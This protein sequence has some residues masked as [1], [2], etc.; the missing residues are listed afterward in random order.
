MPPFR[1]T[2]QPGVINHIVSED[3]KLSPKSPFIEVRKHLRR[4]TELQSQLADINVAAR[5]AVQELRG[6]EPPA[7]EGSHLGAC[8]SL[9][10][11]RAVRGAGSL[12]RRPRWRSTPRSRAS[13][14]RSRLT[15]RQRA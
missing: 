4:I 3:E 14:R 10:H 11:S 13:R 2:Y 8:R 15:S 7:A 1:N 5:D 6:I 9:S 12:P